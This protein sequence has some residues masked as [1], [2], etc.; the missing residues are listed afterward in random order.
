MKQLNH[1]GIGKVINH[2]NAKHGIKGLSV[3]TSTDGHYLITIDEKKVVKI[4][5]SL[6]INALI[7]NDKM[8]LFVEEDIPTKPPITSTSTVADDNI[9]DAAEQEADKSGF[10]MNND[11]MIKALATKL[12]PEFLKMF[13]TKEEINTA[14]NNMKK[15]TVQG[16][17]LASSL[18]DLSKTVKSG[19]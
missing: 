3:G 12:A 4:L 2:L 7:V 19:Q 5:E 1:N 17:E 11:A 10:D 9:K 6:K 8:K 15:G 18:K 13:P 14:L 16:N